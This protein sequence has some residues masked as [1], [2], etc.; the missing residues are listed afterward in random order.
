MIDSSIK[1][2][3]DIRYKK[4][5]IR[6]QEEQVN[7]DHELEFTRLAIKRDEENSIEKRKDVAYRKVW[8]ITERKEGKVNNEQV[9]EI[10]LLGIVV[11]DE[12]TDRKKEVKAQRDNESTNEDDDESTNE[13]DDEYTSE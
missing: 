7:K 4:V 1:E 13:Y 5:W 2:N 12:S 8:K 3:V 10:V 11:K 9:Q 6:K